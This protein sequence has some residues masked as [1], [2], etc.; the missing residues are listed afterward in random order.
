MNKETQIKLS[1]LGKEFRERMNLSVLP[2]DEIDK[3][4]NDAIRDRKYNGQTIFK[5]DIYTIEQKELVSNKEYAEKHY[6]PESSE[7]KRIGDSERYPF[8]ALQIDKTIYTID[9][10][11]IEELISKEIKR[12]D[13]FKKIQY[14]FVAQIP[15][16]KYSKMK[17]PYWGYPRVN[18][19]SMLSYNYEGQLVDRTVTS[20]PS[21]GKL[22]VYYGR[23]K[24]QI[25][26]K[27]GDIVEIADLYTEPRNPGIKLGRIIATP[28]DIIEQCCKSPSNYLSDA[29]KVAILNPNNMQLKKFS[30]PSINVFNPRFPISRELMD[31]LNN[32]KVKE[33][34]ET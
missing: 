9:N 34:W 18:Y 11:S 5:I 19:I 16:D 30:V 23:E 29:Y 31:I 7:F 6:I 12:K 14:I 25:R 32:A 21:F 28:L 3:R 17:E 13:S 22:S 8:T 15:C 20:S 27:E 1:I 33:S 26:F 24:S 4:L 10:N 2:D